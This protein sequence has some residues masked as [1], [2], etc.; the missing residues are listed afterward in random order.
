MF[1]LE[2]L[3]NGKGFSVRVFWTDWKNQGKSHNIEKSENFRQ[4]LFIIF[5]D[6]YMNFEWVEIVGSKGIKYLT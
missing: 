4:M 1:G 2:N 6:I 5:S 3:E